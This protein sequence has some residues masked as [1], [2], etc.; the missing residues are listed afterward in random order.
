MA[1]IVTSYVDGWPVAEPMGKKETALLEQLL[2]PGEKV[3]GQ[4]IGN[5]D[6]AVIVT[7]HHVCIVKT[8]LMAGQ[9][10]GG[11]ST[12]FDFKNIVGV[13]IRTGMI[14]GEFEILAA[15]LANN[16]GNTNNA[17]VEMAKSP[18]GIVF[19][20]GEAPHFNALA[21][22]IRERAGGHSLAP[23][24][25]SASTQSHSH[26]TI[27]AIKQLAELHAAGILTEDE[28]T[29]KKAELLAKM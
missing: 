17:K 2:V 29:N 28:F 4:V 19:Y 10:F 1:K 7:D 13:E 25:A 5:F 9:M 3:L 20:K 21:A 24:S 26:P 14:Q 22:K 8:G 6:Q 18:N 16:Q 23:A 15:G 12:A 11:K 27:E